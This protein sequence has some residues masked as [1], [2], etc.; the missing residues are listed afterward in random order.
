MQSAFS[1][2]YVA[3]AFWHLR[4]MKLSQYLWIRLRNQGQLDD[5]DWL[6]L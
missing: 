5:F 3:N 2:G 6:G 1:A 4:M